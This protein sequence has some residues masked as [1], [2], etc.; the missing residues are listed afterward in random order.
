MNKKAQAGLGYALLGVMVIGVVVLIYFVA[1]SGAPAQTVVQES[2]ENIVAESHEGKVASIGVYV[3]DLSHN[4]VNT[5]RAATV[6]CQDDTGSF[7]IDGTTASTS[8]EITGKTTIGK[9]VTC[10]AFDGTYQTME[11]EVTVIDEEAEHIVIDAFTSA[12]T[13]EATV[14]D[15]TFTSANDGAVN[16]SV[17]ADGSDSFA[18]MKFKN[19][20]T[21]SFISLGGF[22]VDVIEDTNITGI[23][24]VGA[25]SLFGFIDTPLVKIVKSDL[26]TGVSARKS[27][28]DY[29]FEI[30]ADAGEIG[31]QALIIN[32]NDYIE[33]GPITF[34]SDVGCTAG[35]TGAR[36][37]IR[38]F[39]KGYFRETKNEGVGYAHETDASSASVIETDIACT[40]VYC[41]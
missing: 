1:T 20:N 40:T 25:V 15:T 11:P 34:E 36:G 6:Y 2:L 22:S 13:A 26:T 16:L 33:T 41:K 7:I 10:W 3:R 8:A 37:V 28:W 39:I 23:D 35:S 32:E 17:G 21:D 19:N 27:Q 12:I 24:M 14:Y 30:D 4:N 29:V 18:K 38:G 9:T 5:K 31:N